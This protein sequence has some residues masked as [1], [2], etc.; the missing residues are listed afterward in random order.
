MPV[1]IPP[2]YEKIEAQ[3][4]VNGASQEEIKRSIDELNLVGAATLSFPE[5]LNKFYLFGGLPFQR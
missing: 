4:Q 3:M 5:R 2:V 1:V